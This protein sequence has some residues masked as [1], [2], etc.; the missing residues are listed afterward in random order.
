MKNKIII[1]VLALVIVGSGIFAYVDYS[2]RAEAERVAQEKVKMQQDQAAR[3]AEQAR[4]AAEAEAAKQSEADKTVYKSASG[5]FS[6]RLVA[7][8]T[9]TKTTISFIDKAGTETV[10][11]NLSG[12]CVVENTDGTSKNKKDGL[13]F[14]IVKC[15]DAGVST[16][17]YKKGADIKLATTKEQCEDMTVCKSFISTSVLGKF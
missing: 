3:D 6:W 10:I 11:K 7:S 5:E 9:A 17:I 8:T 15:T 1:I 4:V 2:A 14:P 16:Y 12:E 13:E